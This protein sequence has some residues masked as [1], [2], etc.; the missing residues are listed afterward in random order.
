MKQKKRS[1]HQLNLG[2]QVSR[3]MYPSLAEPEMREEMEKIAR[4][5]KKRPPKGPTLL[6]HDQRGAMSPLGGK[7]R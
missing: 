5:N 1:W 4:A 7:A 3:V 6:S 2:E